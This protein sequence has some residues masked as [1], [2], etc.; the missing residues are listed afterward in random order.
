MRERDRERGVYGPGGYRKNPT[1]QRIEDVIHG[2]YVGDKHTNRSFT[3]VVDLQG[4]II[5]GERNGNGRDGDPTPHP[6]LI[7]GK[8]PKVQMAG[9]LDVRG[10]KIYSYDDRSGHFKPNHRSLAAADEA[11]DKLPRS[12]FHRHFRRRH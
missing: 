5:I 3:Y 6:T 12:L 1:A 2:N 8:S 4:N 9:I 10:G 11:F 7:G